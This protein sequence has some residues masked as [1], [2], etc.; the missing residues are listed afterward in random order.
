MKSFFLIVLIFFT[1]SCGFKVVDYSKLTNFKIVDIQ[2]KGEKRINYKLK[3]KLLINNNDIDAKSINLNLKTSKQRT[4]KEKS[5][6]NEITKYSL[7]IV[8]N[9]EALHNNEKFVFTITKIGDY[10]VNDKY[11]ITLNNE[12]KLIELLTNDISDKIYDE[13][14]NN[15]NDS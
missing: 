12:K 6:R 10:V 1:S 5:I 15:L 11:S 2:T 8:V 14:I 4:I 13:L 7:K 9:V 3:N